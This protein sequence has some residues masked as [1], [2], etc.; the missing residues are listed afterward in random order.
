ML[1]LFKPASVNRVIKKPQVS[2]TRYKIALVN[3][4]K[5]IKEENLEKEFSQ[6]IFQEQAGNVLSRAKEEAAKLLTVAQTKAQEVIGQAKKE[7]FAAGY[8]EGLEKASEEAKKI[9]QDAYVLLDQV[10]KIREETVKNSEKE[11][12]HLAC[13]IAAKI[14]NT[15]LTVV[16]ETILQIA[17]EVIDLLTGKDE[18]SLL[19]NPEEISVFQANREEILKN[20]P[21]GARVNILAD[22]GIKPGGLKIRTN[23]EDVDATLDGRWEVVRDV[24]GV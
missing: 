15:Q 22:P 7:G 23:Q 2:Q 4:E 17:K 8:R 24:L 1:L 3:K 6:D 18:L 19:V 14:V 5:I 13:E 11:I 9:R 21:A 16:P 10:Q 20:L 12:V